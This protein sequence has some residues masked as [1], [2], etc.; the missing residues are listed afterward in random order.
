MQIFRAFYKIDLCDRI[1][2]IYESDLVHCT[3][4]ELRICF[5]IIYES[6]VAKMFFEFFFSTKDL[7]IVQKFVDCTKLKSTKVF[8]S[9]FTKY[10]FGCIIA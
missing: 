4:F 2:Q 9:K 1:F 3:Q 6:I 7:Y 10:Y 8:C 5:C